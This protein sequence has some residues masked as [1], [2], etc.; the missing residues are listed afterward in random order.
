MRT[1][2]DGSIRLVVN[3]MGEGCR[4]IRTVDSHPRQS[5]ETIVILMELL[6]LGDLD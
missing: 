2:L 4:V 1:C 6:C 5:L 3:R